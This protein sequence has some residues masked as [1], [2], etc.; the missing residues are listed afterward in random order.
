MF[1]INHHVKVQL[2]GLGREVYRQKMEE[3]NEELI[4]SRIKVKTYKKE[5]DQGWSEWQMWEL[6]K[7]FGEHMGNGSELLFELIINI[8]ITLGED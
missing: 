5:N 6:M 7:Y 1:N 4:N 2:T 8:P 3:I